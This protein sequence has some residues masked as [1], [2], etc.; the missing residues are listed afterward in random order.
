MK[1][2]P[3]F[4]GVVAGDTRAVARAISLVEEGTAAGITLLQA[5]FPHTGRAQ[6]IGITGPPGAGKSTL[7][8]RLTTEIRKEGKAVGVIAVDPTSP[9][10]G[11]AVAC[12]SAAW[13]HAV[14]SAA[15][16]APPATSRSSSTPRARMSS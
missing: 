8:D 14:I 13:R 11:G 16:R 5:I 15:S 1:P 10:T 7:V 12:S 2:D 3:I 6:L 4:E 9:F